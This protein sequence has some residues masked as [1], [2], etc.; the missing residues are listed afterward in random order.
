MPVITRRRAGVAVERRAIEADT[1]AIPVTPATA[2]EMKHCVSQVDASGSAA[3]TPRTI[4]RG[5]GLG[6]CETME[7]MATDSPDLA[8]AARFDRFF[9]L[10]WGLM[11]THCLSVV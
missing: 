8:E 3:S 10:I 4:P 7:G 6:T 5:S 11:S 9:D 1:T 2:A